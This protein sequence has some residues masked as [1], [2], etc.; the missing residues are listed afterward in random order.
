MAED[1][2]DEGLTLL[3]DAWFGHVKR[4]ITTFIVVMVYMLSYVG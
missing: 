2:S 4:S 3:G 1:A